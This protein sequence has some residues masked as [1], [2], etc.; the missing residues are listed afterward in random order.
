MSIRTVATMG[1][2][3]ALAGAAL[4]QQSTPTHKYEKKGAHQGAQ[5]TSDRQFF[6][7]AAHGGMTEVELGRLAADRATNPDVKEF[8]QRM[9]DDHGKA[10]DELKSLASQKNVTLPEDIG[11]ENEAL[12]TRLSKLSGPEFDKAYINAMVRDHNKDVKEFEHQANVASDPDVKAFASK[13]L[14]TLKEHQKM[15]HELQVKL[16]SAPASNK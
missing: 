7:E 15:A 6:M 10:N 11:R 13:T 14:P 16:G 12:K 4:A 2:G 1:L 3:V 9:V 8:G 5:A